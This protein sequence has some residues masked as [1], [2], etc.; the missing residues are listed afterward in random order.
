MAQVAVESVGPEV[1]EDRVYAVLLV[2]FEVGGE[3]L[4]FRQDVAAPKGEAERERFAQDYADSYER[5]YAPPVEAEHAEDDDGV[6]LVADD[7][8]E[9]GEQ[10]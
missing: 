3:V 10:Q 6:L 5:D 4:T 9:I 7:D 8:P 1:D 2:S